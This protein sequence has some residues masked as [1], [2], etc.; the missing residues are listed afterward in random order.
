MYYSLKKEIISFKEQ[1]DL[2]TVCFYAD[3]SIKYS[4]KLKINYLQW[5]SPLQSITFQKKCIKM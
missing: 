2:M 4:K 3:K 1:I 5:K